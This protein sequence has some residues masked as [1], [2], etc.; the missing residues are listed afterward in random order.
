MFP[1][2]VPLKKSNN[3]FELFRP[4]Y[5]FAR[6]WGYVPFS[7]NFDSFPL[8][9]TV[10]ISLVNRILLLIQTLAYL[11]CLALSLSY[12]MINTRKITSLV[13][14]GLN[15]VNEFGIFFGLMFVLADV[16][17]RHKIWR[18]FRTFIRFDGEVLI[19]NQISFRYSP[20]IINI[21]QMYT[22]SACSVDYAN[23]RKSIKWYVTVWITLNVSVSIY[24]IL[25]HTYYH[26]FA[27]AVT[28]YIILLTVTSI[29]VSVLSVYSFLLQNAKIRFTVL[30]KSLR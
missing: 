19:E 26:R 12:H 22:V 3:I 7:V 6:L 10:K 4:V 21:F 14:H 8:P 29:Y 1:L 16:A 15:K 2:Y 9:T 30:N 17:N 5:V 25:I 11:S 23:A 27:M 20:L 18:I 28:G 24:T 13:L